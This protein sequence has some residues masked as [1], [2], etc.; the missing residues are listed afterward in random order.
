M[1]RYFRNCRERFD[2]LREAQRHRTLSDEENRWLLTCIA[3]WFD[4]ADMW[5]EKWPETDRL[6]LGKLA[7]DR[8]PQYAI[9]PE[10]M[11]FR[12]D[13]EL[14]TYFLRQQRQRVLTPEEE[15]RVRKSFKGWMTYAA[16]CSWP[17]SDREW[18]ERMA[19]D[20]ER[21]FLEAAWGDDSRQSQGG[22][23]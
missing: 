22:S 13:I 16:M 3:E 10:A 12:S 11:L 19:P 7:P 9:Q 4:H 14:F 20:Y 17:R 6:W 23:R 5:S 2:C 1:R 21:D 15:E 8:F 18:I